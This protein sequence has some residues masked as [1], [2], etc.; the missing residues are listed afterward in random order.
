MTKVKLIWA[1]SNNGTI[2][3]DGTMPW[4]QRADLQ[5]FKAQ[6]LHQTI[7]MGRKTVLSL[8]SRPLP[9]RQNL[10]L[11]H[12][13]T[14]N[15]PAEFKIVNDLATAYQLAQEADQDL[16]IV[17][18]RAVYEAALPLAD[19]LFVTYLDAEI[20]GDVAMA[21]VDEQ[22]WRGEGVDAGSA[23]EQN[24]YAYRMVHYTRR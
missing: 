20:D 8:G 11:T 24:D 23:D 7:L 6:T 21:P 18:G 9:K 2:G 12:Q 4:H 16:F 22:L 13:A 15:L 3:K 17:G 1:Q 14:L 10:V 19:E 5:F